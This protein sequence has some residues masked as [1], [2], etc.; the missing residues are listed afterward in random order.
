MLGPMGRPSKRSDAA[1]DVLRRKKWKKT[2][3]N[4]RAVRVG[5]VATFEGVKP[6]K[7]QAL[8]LL[9][10][11]A[12][13]FGAW[14]D[15]DRGTD[16]KPKSRIAVLDEI[17]DVVQAACNLVAAFGVTDFAPYMQDC[18]IRNE[19]RGRYGNTGVE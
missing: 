18:R 13:V 10:E 8:K 16:F 17:A 12:E 3:L 11:A 6:D 15:W 4:S 2:K 7:A 9:E 5:A 14:Q 1:H 19:E